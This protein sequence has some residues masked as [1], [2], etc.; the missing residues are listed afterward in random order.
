MGLEDRLRNWAW[1]VSWGTV[2][3]QPDSTCRSFE[4]NYIPELGNLYAPEEPHYEPDHKDGEAIEQAIKGLPQELRKV[5]KA[6][7]VSHPY[8][9]QNQ[10]AHHLRKS[11]TRLE[12]DL[13]NAKKRLQDQLDKKA[14]SK[15]YADLLKV[16]G[17][18]DNREWDFRNLQSWD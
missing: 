9:S 12:T 13:T 14:K 11:T 2:V 4:K 3:P 6:R 16:S 18:K 15:D 7:Y 17:E 8:A 10:L 5:L 1:Y